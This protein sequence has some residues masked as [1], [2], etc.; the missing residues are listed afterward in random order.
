MTVATE[1]ATVVDVPAARAAG[2]PI[3][4]W[5]MAFLIMT[6]AMIF[7]GLL[8]SYFFIRAS[9]PSW[10]LGGIAE[11]P[12]LRIGIMT[13]VLLASSIPV[14]WAEH[15]IKRGDATQ[16]QAGLFLGFVMGAAFL[17]HQAIEYHELAF[18]WRD[19]AYASLFYVITGLHGAH[20]LVGLVMSAVVMLKAATGRFTA[21][22]HQTVTIFGMY[23]HFVD[24]VWCFVF[25]SL[26]L[27]VAWA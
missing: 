24:V 17:A 25:P 21:D 14:V 13:V 23:W 16:L 8:S 27:S 20:L 10:P 7:A 5:G 18:G 1:T 3:A 4:W 26:Y 22:R 15:G 2:R 12:L 11:P 6:E 19:N 9:S